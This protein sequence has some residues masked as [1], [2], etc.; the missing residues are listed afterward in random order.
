MKLL[1]ETNS[2]LVSYRKVRQIDGR[3]ILDFLE[4]KSNPLKS[5]PSV[6]KIVESAGFTGS[7]ESK[8]RI[9]V[10]VEVETW[11]T[12]KTGGQTWRATVAMSGFQ[13][14]NFILCGWT[15][16]Q[17]ITTPAKF[18]VNSTPNSSPKIGVVLLSNSGR[19]AGVVLQQLLRPWS[20]LLR[21]Y[22]S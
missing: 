12:F 22:S 20:S 15:A 4:R 8:W 18:G 5:W 14:G 11:D 3:Q 1:E 6:K 10:E 19:L 2:S 21:D 13:K 7:T 17:S 9:Q 16:K